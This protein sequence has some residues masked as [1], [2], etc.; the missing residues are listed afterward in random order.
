MFDPIL[1]ACRMSAIPL[2]HLTP[3]ETHYLKF[4]SN[5]FPWGSWK[6]TLK[7]LATQNSHSQDLHII[8]D[9]HLSTN[10]S[11]GHL[12]FLLASLHGSQYFFIISPWKLLF[13]FRFLAI[14]IHPYNLRTPTLSRKLRN[15]HLP[16]FVSFIVKVGTMLF[17]T[18]CILEQKLEMP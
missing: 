10:L 2:P 16:S 6:K 1:K 4:F 13:L 12:S 14:W 8:D 15:L 3:Q 5:Y 9:E 18:L 17:P 11:T 7:R